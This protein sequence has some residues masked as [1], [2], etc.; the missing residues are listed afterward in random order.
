MYSVYASNFNDGITQRTWSASFKQQCD[1]F[2]V[3]L[4]HFEATRKYDNFESNFWQH[5]TLLSTIA[6]H[7]CI[8]IHV[9]W[10]TRG[11][12]LSVELWW[13]TSATVH[14]TWTLQAATGSLHGQT[15][16]SHQQQLS[17]SI[18]IIIIII[19]IKSYS[20]FC[21]ALFT[22]RPWALTRTSDICSVLR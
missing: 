21:V 14:E 16:S 15:A 7:L 6:V 5:I 4:H 10:L 11:Q 18:P 22:D 1:L 20:H 2:S 3:Y 19:I 12:P 8:I 13:A 9:C 17:A